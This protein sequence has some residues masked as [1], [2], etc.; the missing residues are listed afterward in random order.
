[1][2]VAGHLFPLGPRGWD[3]NL[4]TATAGMALFFI[5]SGF[6]ITRFL[7]QGMEVR[8]F[9]LRRFFRVVPLA[10]SVMVLLLIAHWPPLTTWLA[11]VLFFANLP[12]QHL[13][14]GGAHLWSLC[15]EMQFYV[16]MALLIG[17][18]GRRSLY[19]IPVFCL[20][21]TGLRIATGH[22]VDI[23][24]WFR[25]DE[26]LAG[27]CVALAFSGTFGSRIKRLLGH[28]NPLCAFPLLLLSSHP[29]SG[30]F[31]YLRPYLAAVTISSTLCSPH[32]TRYKILDNK[33]SS[34]IAAISY[35][36][37]IF[38]GALSA[39]WLGAGDTFVRY[40]KRPLLVAV[41]WGLAHLSTFWFERSCI[42]LGK[43]ISENMEPRPRKPGATDYGS[44]ANPGDGLSIPAQEARFRR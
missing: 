18:L 31:Q 36:V 13:L 19:A 25:I 30:D 16:G 5:L 10:W 12:P 29:V 28:I 40:A 44:V 42:R 22:H 41:V 11:N 43:R 24:T 17:A 6:L 33:I 21:V 26:I 8:V 3:L 37:Y 1:M 14:E 39:T 15:V 35:A 34:Y 20:V 7:L 38:H 27:G 9:L 2:V 4:M 32:A 23:V